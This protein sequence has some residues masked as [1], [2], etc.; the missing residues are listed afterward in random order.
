MSNLDEIDDDE[1]NEESEWELFKHFQIFKESE[2]ML[3][4]I[5][6]VTV[7]IPNFWVY[8]SAPISLIF[9]FSNPELGEVPFGFNQTH[10]FLVIKNCFQNSETIFQSI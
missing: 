9:C 2:M 6:I 1:S 5:R 10:Y 3:F 7:F 8:K 4:E